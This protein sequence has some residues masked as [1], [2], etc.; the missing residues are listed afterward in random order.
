MSQNKKKDKKIN[1]P[2]DYENLYKRALADYQN[3]QKQTAREKEEFARYVKGNLIMEFIPIYENL[4]TAID[5]SGEE[6]SWLTGVKYVIKQFEDMLANNGV[7]IINPV[8]E[9]FNPHEHEAVEK[10]ETEDETKVGKVAKVL[11]Q[12][13]KLGDKVIQVAKVIV[14]SEKL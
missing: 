10:Q 14:Y 1:A 11:K 12:G 2:D 3:L 8:G 5:H 4:R 7:Q 13:Y 6:N 9:E